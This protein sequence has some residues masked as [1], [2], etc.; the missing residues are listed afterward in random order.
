MLLNMYYTLIRDILSSALLDTWEKEIISWGH[1][2]YM[3]PV[4]EHSLEE[5][6]EAVSVGFVEIILVSYD[7]MKNHI[8]HLKD[9]NYELI[10][11]DEVHNLANVNSMKYLSAMQLTHAHCRIGLTGTPMMNKTED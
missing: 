1:F 9:V 3:R 8:H 5:I 4:N 2:L 11:F 6:E 10:V 7:F